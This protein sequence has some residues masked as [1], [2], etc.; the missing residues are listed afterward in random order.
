MI[1]VENLKKSFRVHQKQPGLKGSLKGLINRK[2]EE[3]HALKGV[4]LNIS[5]G[6]IVGMVGANGAGKTTLIKLLA[7]IIKLRSGKS[8]GFYP[9]GARE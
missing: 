8:A 2:W 3:K 6:E 4:S 5:A 7:G 9:M 1:Q